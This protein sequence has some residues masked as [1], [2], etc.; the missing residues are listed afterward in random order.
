SQV[1]AMMLSGA[2]CGL[3]AGLTYAGVTGKIGDGFGQNWGFLAIPVALL[4]GLEPLGASLV[5]LFFG[6]LFAGCEN[7]ERFTPIGSTIVFVVQAATVLGFVG[8]ERWLA[9]RRLKV[10]Q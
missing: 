4:G 8:V 6:A 7:L 5:A 10:G 9:M 2:L 3:A 1:L